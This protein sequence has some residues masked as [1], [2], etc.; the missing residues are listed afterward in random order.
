MKK[1]T[2]KIMIV[3]D[4]E[5]IRSR[6]SLMLTNVGFTTIEAECGEDAL[7]IAANEV[8]DAVLLDIQMPGINGIETCRKLR[9][10]EQYRITPILFLSANDEDEILMEAFS[11]GGDDYIHKTMKPFVLHARLQGHLQRA[12][13]YHELENLRKNLNRFVSTRTQEMVERYTKTGILPLPEQQDVCIMF[14]DI[15]DYTSLSQKINSEEVFTILGKHLGKQVELVYQH[16]GYVDKF[17]GDGIMTVFE[18]DDKNER[19]CHCAMD[20][21]KMTQEVWDSKHEV[22][23]NPGIGIYDGRVILGNIG[24]SEHLDYTVIGNTVNI[25][26]RLCEHA[27]PMSIVLTTSVRDGILNMQG[28]HFT[29][30]HDVKIK[31][32]DKPLTI[33]NLIPDLKDS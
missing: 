29:N 32:I 7:R 33:I 28:L 22:Q 6:Y 2:N 16:G 9:E 24:S 8:V 3:D 25:A 5:S 19:A 13:Y 14:T 30:E 10:M 31:G 20:I 23:F 4:N 11:A 12:Q 1:A 17:G 27:E 26:A 15:R 21:I 18:G